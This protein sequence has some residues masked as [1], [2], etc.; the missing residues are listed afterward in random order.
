[1]NWKAPLILL[2][3]LVLFSCA[4][5]REEEVKKIDELLVQIEQTENKFNAIDSVN[6]FSVYTKMITDLKDLHLFTDTLENETFKKINNANTHLAALTAAT[7]YFYIISS[8]LQHSKKQVQNLKQDAGNGLIEKAKFVDR[9]KEE[10]EIILNL[11]Q[12]IDSTYKDLDL[13][14]EETKKLY[15]TVDSIVDYLKNTKSTQTDTAK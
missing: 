7:Q 10:Q 8:E 5:N 3:S 15:P 4:N 12:V 9:L 1:M 2:F 6:L 11:T 14:L 13:K